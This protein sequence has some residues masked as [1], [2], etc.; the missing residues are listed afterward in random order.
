MNNRSINWKEAKAKLKQIALPTIFSFLGAITVLYPNNPSNSTLPSRDSGVFLYVGWRLI[1]GDIPYK[2][3]W[4]H[5]PPLIYFLNALG[6]TLTPDSLW[7][8]W[9]IQFLFIFLAIFWVYKTLD[10]EFGIIP[11]IASII[12]LTS[13]LLNVMEEG[14]VTEE[15]ALVFQSLCLWLFTKAKDNNYPYRNS[16]WIGLC[17]GLAFYFKQTT[18]GVWLAYGVLLTLIRFRQRKWPVRDFLYLTAGWLIPVI[19]FVIYFYFNGALRDFWEQAFAYNFLYIN[20]FEGFRNLLRVFIKGFAFLGRG[21]VLY[22][23]IAGWLAAAIYLWLEQKDLL[24]K[25]NLL[26]FLAVIVFP[27]EIFLITLSGRSILHYYLTPL[28]GMAILSGIFIFI[29]A[30]W[31]GRLHFMPTI[32]KIVIQVV[33]LIVVI[34]Y[35]IPVARSFPGIVNTLSKNS[36]DPVIRYVINNTKP[37]DKLLIIGAESVINFLTRREAP[38]RFVYQYPLALTGKRLLFEEYFNEILQDQPTLIIDT[39][40]KSNLTEKLY[41]PLQERSDVVKDGVQY[42]KEHYQ[43]VAQFEE[44]SV[45]RFTE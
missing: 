20:K 17:G 10:K 3:V 7:G 25:S 11:A 38:T 27:I 4:D 18:I 35:Q 34:L 24:K 29:I 42:L 39:R 36:A 28:P 15:Y 16:F 23:A 14:N 44:W 12:I 19:V 1:N 33:A 40:G 22:F 9:A 31:I 5:K 21:G 41:L 43:K 6:L 30:Q 37:D 26:I 45:Y 8:V 32:T 13:G 2:D